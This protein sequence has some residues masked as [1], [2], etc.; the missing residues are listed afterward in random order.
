LLRDAHTPL[1]RKKN[2]D[3]QWITGAHHR[4]DTEHEKIVGNINCSKRT[5]PTFFL[6]V[7]NEG[8]AP[9]AEAIASLLGAAWPEARRR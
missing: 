8:R 2:H 3:Y 4:G 7:L 6:P 1:D 5:F 9:G